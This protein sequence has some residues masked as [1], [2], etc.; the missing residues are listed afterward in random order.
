MTFLNGGFCFILNL[1]RT[2]GAAPVTFQMYFSKLSQRAGAP[3]LSLLDP[4]VA[5]RL[6]VCSTP[7]FHGSVLIPFPPKPMKKLSAFLNVVLR[8]TTNFFFHAFLTSLQLQSML[9][10]SLIRSMITQLAISSSFIHL[11][12]S[13]GFN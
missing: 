7:Q 3:G 12:T 2:G 11:Q 10:S 1:F 5:A 6:P 13:A 8:R 4:S 9:H